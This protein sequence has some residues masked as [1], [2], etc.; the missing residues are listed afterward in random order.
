[1]TSSVTYNR[2]LQNGNWA[3]TL[4][5]GRNRTEGSGEVFSGYLAESTLRFL[6]HNYTWT[7]IENADRTNLLLLGENPLPIAFKERLLARI[8]AYSFGYDH[9]FNFVTHVSSALGGQFTLYG[10]PASL[11]SIYGAHP[12][13]VLL[14]LRFRAIPVQK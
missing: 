7:R 13:G 10:K 4:V 14:F 3:T 1:M 11:D 2:P 8:Q 9:E 12:T 6:G 5:W